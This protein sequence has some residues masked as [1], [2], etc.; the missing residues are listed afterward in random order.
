MPEFPTGVMTIASILKRTTKQ[1]S[2]SNDGVFFVVEDE[3]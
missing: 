3:E 2:I 1:N